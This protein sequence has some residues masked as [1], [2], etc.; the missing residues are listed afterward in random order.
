MLL[1][2]WCA[3]WISWQRSARSAARDHD[4]AT[5]PS[6]TM[7]CRYGGTVDKFTGDGMMAVFG[8]PA[9]LE[10]H[11]LRACMAALAIRMRPSGWRV[12]VD[13]ATPLIAAAE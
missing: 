5:Q 7:V 11:A 4:R 9:A 8:A 13:R 1:L 3:R 10:D 12:E 2:T 6:S